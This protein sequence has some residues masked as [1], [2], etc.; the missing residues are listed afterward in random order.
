MGIGVGLRRGGAADRPVALLGVVL[1]LPAVPHPARRGEAPGEA[2][3]RPPRGTAGGVGV[4]EEEAVHV[5]RGVP[6]VPGDDQVRAQPVDRL[7]G[8]PGGGRAQGVGE[9]V[10]PAVLG[11]AGDAV[12]VGHGVQGDLVPPADGGGLG[13]EEVADQPLHGVGREGLVGVLAGVPVDP[14][15]VRRRHGGVGDGQL[16][17][18]APAVARPEPAA[19]QA[20]VLGQA[21]DVGQVGGVVVGRAQSQPRLPGGDVEGHADRPVRPSSRR[22]A[23]RGAPAQR[24]RRRRPPR[25][26]MLDVDEVPPG[27]APEGALV[28]VRPCPAGGGAGEVELHRDRQGSAGGVA[29]EQVHPGEGVAQG[30]GPLFGAGEHAQLARAEGD[31]AGRIARGAPV[32]GD[33]PGDGGAGV[34]P[35]GRRPVPRGPLGGAHCGLAAR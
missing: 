34:R 18:L 16:P 32:L 23:A 25:S 6:V 15:L 31:Q 20:R 4:C 8:Q 11:A 26:Q 13:R 35:P 19:A 1:R 9:V 3:E 2:V 10:A 17:V 7:P 5:P 14:P 29:A 24:P 27:H 30:A 33:V 22:P 12:H 21:G 28:E